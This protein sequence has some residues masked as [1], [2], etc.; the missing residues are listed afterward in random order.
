MEL[1][2]EEHDFLFDDEGV[3]WI[4]A[5]PSPDFSAACTCFLHLKLTSSTVGNR[6]SALLEGCSEVRLH[7]SKDAVGFI[8]APSHERPSHLCIR[9]LLVAPRQA[10]QTRVLES[11]RRLAAAADVRYSLHGCAP[12]ADGS[13]VVRLELGVSSRAVSSGLSSKALQQHLVQVLAYTHEAHVLHGL[14]QRNEV[15]LFVMLRTKSS[16]VAARPCSRFRRRASGV[17]R[18][19]SG[20][21]PD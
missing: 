13:A 9:A 8:A 17:G 20:A 18:A 15:R 2:C 7:S 14:A 6:T 16:A 5:A 12:H 21:C 1:V 19:V 3:P 4:D 11:L 10:R